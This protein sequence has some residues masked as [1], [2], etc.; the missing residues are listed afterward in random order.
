MLLTKKKDDLDMVYKNLAYNFGVMMF[1]E[2]WDK[3]VS[4]NY[5]LGT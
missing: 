4:E 2:M 1:T 3:E 5:A